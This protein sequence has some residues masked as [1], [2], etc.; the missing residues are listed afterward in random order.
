[1]LPALKIREALASDMFDAVRLGF[2]TVAGM[3]RHVRVRAERVPLYARGLKALP[4]DE[5]YD[6]EHHYLGGMEDTAA[7]VLAVEAVNFGSG[8]KH[9]L[10]E[11]GFPLVGDSLYFTVST[12]LKRH[13]ETDGPMTAETMASLSDTECCTLFRLD[14]GKAK[15]REL[16]ELFA[17]SLRELGGH[18]VTDHNGSFLGFVHAAEGSAERMVR[19]LSR[20]TR[21]ND[22]HFYRGMDVPFYKRAQLAAAALNIEF[23]RLGHELFHDIDRLTLFADNDVPH[24]LHTDGI[25]EYAP[26]LAARIAAG[27]EIPSGSE[28]EVEI[29]ACAG[30]AVELLAGAAG[31][32]A[33]DVDFILW[34]RS[35]EDPIYR[36]SLSH[37]TLGRFY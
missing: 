30:H 20:L 34:H 3:A 14:E 12:A 31:M 16:G 6:L 18:I 5:T 36:E 11:E 13:F 33:R 7:Y 32:A 8:Y 28:E 25:L 35:A 29:R 22:I 15:S 19:H 2:E 9:F 10:K 4:P 27:D 24:V 23:G 26:E 1:M 37:R 17:A 21:F